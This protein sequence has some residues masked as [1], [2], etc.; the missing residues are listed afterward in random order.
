[1]E[2]TEEQIAKLE[3]FDSLAVFR[4]SLNMVAQLWSV[5]FESENNEI[6]LLKNINSGQWGTMV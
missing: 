4:H 3:L 5:S 2:T 6:I 1:M